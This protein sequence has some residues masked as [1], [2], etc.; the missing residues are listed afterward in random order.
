MDSSFFWVEVKFSGDTRLKVSVPLRKRTRPAAA[1]CLEARYC[2]CVC[3]CP[4]A[5]CYV[6]K[7]RF[8]GEYECL[9]MNLYLAA[10][11]TLSRDVM[12][13]FDLT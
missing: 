10:E 1:S 4:D 13:S 5:C 9:T 8:G 11:R 12:F 2:S 6:K 7:K 3:V